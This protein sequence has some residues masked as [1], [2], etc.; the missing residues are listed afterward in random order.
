MGMSFLR[1][2]LFGGLKG[3]PAGKQLL[4][5]LFFVGGVQPKKRQTHMKGESDVSIGYPK[6]GRGTLSH[7]LQAAKRLVPPYFMPWIWVLEPLEPQSKPGWMKVSKGQ[8]QHF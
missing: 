5:L 8:S 1:V 7:M 3:K 6:L 2:H 4:L